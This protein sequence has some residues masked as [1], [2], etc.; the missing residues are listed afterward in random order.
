M[1]PS[2]TITRTS[3]DQWSIDTG[4]NIHAGL[5]LDHA[6]E[7]CLYEDYRRGFTWDMDTRSQCEDG[8]LSL[9]VGESNEIFPSTFT[10]EE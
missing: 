8:L 1:T 10:E 4:D 2:Y 9:R 3:D 6:C 7:V 5:E